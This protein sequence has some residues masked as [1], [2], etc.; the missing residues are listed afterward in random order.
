MCDQC[1]E[2]ISHALF[3]CD[4]PRSIWSF[5]SGRPAILEN[6]QMV[7]IDMAF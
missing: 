7:I 1:I 6:R 4:T 3:D 5:W 2:N